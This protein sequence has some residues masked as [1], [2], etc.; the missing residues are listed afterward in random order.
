MPFPNTKSTYATYRLY[1]GRCQDT[2]RQFMAACLLTTMTPSI[3]SLVVIWLIGRYVAQGAGIGINAGRIRGIN[4]KIGSESTAYRCCPFPQKFEATVRCCTPKW[5]QR[6]KRDS[7][8]P[9]LAP[10]NR[11]HSSSQK[12][13]RYRKT[14]E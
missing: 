9:N 13:Q 5:H 6:W 10:K 4:S 2:L 11:G 3:A 12:Q 8:L 14:T 7:P 1:H